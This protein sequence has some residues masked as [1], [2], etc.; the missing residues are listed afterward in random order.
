M[1]VTNIACIRFSFL[2]FLSS[3]ISLLRFGCF[4]GIAVYWTL[5]F[6]LVVCLFV[7]LAECLKHLFLCGICECC[8]W[9]IAGVEKQTM[10]YKFYCVLSSLSLPPILLSIFTWIII[11]QFQ[12]DLIILHAAQCNHRMACGRTL[13]IISK[14]VNCIRIVCLP[15]CHQS[16]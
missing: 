10:K 7:A 8:T 4:F 3:S 14:W 6:W 15:F 9:R 2:C 11:K 1:Y 13:H 5:A 12:A 16:T